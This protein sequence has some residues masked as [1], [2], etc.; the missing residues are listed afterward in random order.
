[1]KQELILSLLLTT[2]LFGSCDFLDYS[3]RSFAT[4]EDAFSDFGKTEAILT[5][6]YGTLPSGFTGVGDAMLDAATDD[7]V[8]AWDVAA[9]HNFYNGVWSSLSTIDAQWSHFYTGIRRTNLFLENATDKVLEDYK[10]AGNEYQIKAKRWRFFRCEARFLRAYYHF[11]LAKR[12]GA[13]PLVDHTLDPNKANKIPR[14]DFEDVISWI[15]AECNEIAPDLPETYTNPDETPLAETGR[16]TRGAALALRSRALLYLASPLHNPESASDYRQKWLDAAEAAHDLIASG[17]YSNDLPSWNLVFNNWRTTNTELIL[18]RRQDNS[19]SFEVANV[20]IGYE[21]GNSGNCPTQN[22]VDCYEMKATGKGIHEEGSGY[23]STDPYAGRDPRLKMTVLCNGDNW[24]G[25]KI[26]SH[27]GGADGKPRTGASP[28]GY[29]LKKNVVENTVISGANKTNTEHC[30]ILFRYAEVLLNYAEAM[31]EAYGPYDKGN[32]TLT[33]TEAVNFVRKRK[34][35]DMPEF[36]AGLT[37]D[38]FRNKIRNERRVE[39][40]FENHRMWDLRRWQQG[41]LTRQ[42]YGMDITLD[43]VTGVT[44]Y[45]PAKIADRQWDEKMN[46]YPVPQSEIYVT[47]GVISQN[48][49]W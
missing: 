21:G 18:E 17:I 45:S 43:A 35:V 5:A 1:M 12:Y 23:D 36:P 42:I 16:I 8:Y 20:S 19:R 3:E 7:A 27:V 22:L 41:K 24:K 48:P 11:E 14:T 44:T 37:Q 6:A 34:G 33:A 28:S 10:W 46:F 9:I 39:L 25:R 2:L 4:K 26:E 31:N 47:N 49:G 38:E 32:F 40:A 30:W 13:I 29:Y 15:A